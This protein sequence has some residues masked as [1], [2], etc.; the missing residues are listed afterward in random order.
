MSVVAGVGEEGPLVSVR[1]DAL[2][3]GER[4][5]LGAMRFEVGCG[6]VLAVLGPS[7]CG[8]STL[9][10]L[11][12]GLEPG[13]AGR[14]AV[15]GE[16]PAAHAGRS[17]FV[18]QEPRLLPWLTVAENVGF[19][20][21]L[22][23]A[24]ALRHGRVAALLGEVGLAHAAAMYP[25]ALSGGMAQRVAIA[26]G[27]FTEPRLL[28]LDEPFSALDP[29]T[30]MRLQDLLLQLTARHGTTLLLVT[31]DVDEALYL[32]DRVL[33]MDADPGRIVAAIKVDVPRVGPVPAVPGGPASLRQRQHPRLARLREDVLAQMD[34][35]PITD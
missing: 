23:K 34:C 8:K 12:A 33:L 29:F 11:V 2:C 27:L 3:F 4:R 1:V 6:E 35:R 26:R 19:A 21:G 25:K 13:F 15:H 7:G 24:A 17:G 14:V 9:L 30:R 5:V 28:L 31:H 32:S 16:A 10:R 22:D 20:A 18:F